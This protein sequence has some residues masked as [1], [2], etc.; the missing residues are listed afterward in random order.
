MGVSLKGKRLGLGLLL[1]LMMVLISGCSTMKPED[2]EGKGPELVLEDYFA[3][4]TYAWGLFQDRFG[5]VRRQFRVVVD[6]QWQEQDQI[7]KLDEHFLYDDG[8]RDRRVWTIKKPAPHTY[9][10]TAGDVIGE[11]KGH[12]AGN[13]LNWEYQM[14]LAVGDGH[15]KVH[16]NDWMWLQPGGAL[17]NRATVTKWGVTLGTV[18]IFF[19]KDPGSPPMDGWMHISGG[20]NGP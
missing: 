14:N 4:K 6:G 12:T 9:V 10:G 1:S 2:F 7:L 13:A 11:A 16:F 19:S 5:K 3:G 15:W 8:E 17:I 18:S 20:E